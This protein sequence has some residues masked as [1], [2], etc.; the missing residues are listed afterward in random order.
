VES[1][2]EEEIKSSQT[3]N[4]NQRT[5]KK[6]SIHIHDSAYSGKTVVRGSDKSNVK[7]VIRLKKNKDK[8]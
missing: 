4:T 7:K 1:K 2:T 3:S 8:R 5:V 6:K